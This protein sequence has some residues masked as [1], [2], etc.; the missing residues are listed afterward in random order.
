MLVKIIDLIYIKF[1]VF[2]AERYIL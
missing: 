1:E 2:T